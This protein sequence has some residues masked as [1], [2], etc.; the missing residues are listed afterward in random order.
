VCRES[1][2]KRLATLARV[3]AARVKAAG[4]R[5]RA[6]EYV[7]EDKVPPKVEY[8]LTEW[9]QALCPALDEL[10]SWAERRPTAPPPHPAPRGP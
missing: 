9:G 3:V 2:L 4:G 8:H 6:S 7:H 10:P 5:A 1:S